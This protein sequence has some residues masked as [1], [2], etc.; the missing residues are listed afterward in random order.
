VKM[1]FNANDLSQYMFAYMFAY[2]YANILGQVRD[3][4]LSVLQQSVI[5]THDSFSVF[6]RLLYTVFQKNMALVLMIYNGA[7]FFGGGGHGV[8]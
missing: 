4:P 5:L 1:V 3:I 2:M 8:F 6:L 7:A